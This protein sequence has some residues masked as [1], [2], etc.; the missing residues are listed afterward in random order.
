MRHLGRRRGD[1]RELWGLGLAQTRCET[2]ESSLRGNG[3]WPV[4]SGQWAV[5]R[6]WMDGGQRGCREWLI[7]TRGG[8]HEER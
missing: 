5:V 7:E 6:H 4:G 2:L 1:G 8:G 3:K